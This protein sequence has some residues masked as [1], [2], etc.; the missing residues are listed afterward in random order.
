MGLL[1]RPIFLCFILA[2]SFV[3]NW[4][5][6]LVIFS[7]PECDTVLFYSASV[8]KG[9]LLIWLSYL[10]VYTLFDNKERNTSVNAPLYG[11]LL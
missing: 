4:L 2:E 7:L 11:I 3:N 6:T 8:R 1:L 5:E 10:F 9:S